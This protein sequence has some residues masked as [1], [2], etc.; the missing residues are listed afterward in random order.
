MPRGLYLRACTIYSREGN[1]IKYSLRTPIITRGM[2]IWATACSVVV[3]LSIVSY[4]LVRE[5]RNTE[6]DAKRSTLNIVQLINRDIRNTFSIYDSALINLIE[7]LQTQALSTLTPQ[8]QQALLFDRSNE[9]PSNAGFY[10]LDAQGKLIS[11][12]TPHV[13]APDNASLQ[14]WFTAQINPINDELYISQPYLANPHSQ[15]W[16]LILSRRISAPDGTFAGVAVGQ[17]KLAYFQS[18][19]RGLDIGPSGNISL[20]GTDGTLV[21]QYPPTSKISIGQDLS[22]AP[23]FIRILNEPF[24]SFMAMSGIYHHERLFNFAKV[25]DLPL[26]VVAAISA[27]S[28]FNNWQHTALLIGSATL[29]LCLGLLWLTWLLLRELHL[30]HSAERELAALASTDPMTGLANRR[31]LDRTLDLEWR[32]AQR[33]GHPVS[34]IMID[35]DHFK[36]FNDSYGHQAGDEAIRQVAQVIKAHVRRP[37]DLTARYGG[38]EF[39]LVLTETDAPGTRQLSEKIRLAV[40]HMAPVMP[41]HRTLTV[42]VGTCTRYAKPGEHQDTLLSAADKALYQA[43]KAGRNRVVNINE[44]GLN[45]LKPKSAS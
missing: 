21:M 3:I 45:A 35:I 41:G 32:R 22:Q 4:L 40:E 16:V 37:A 44:T 19:F 15:D 9:T 26:I 38:E 5:Y 7:L 2:L 42:S 43:K 17:L 20:L 23:N 33:T 1:A 36:S 18:L 27:S 8:I 39:A 12:S 10:V 24:G 13:R 11:R 30:R 31:T 6:E 34:L 28:I 14:P 25:H 29:L